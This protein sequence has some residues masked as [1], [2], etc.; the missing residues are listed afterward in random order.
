MRYDSTKSPVRRQRSLG[1]R[2][3]G[4]LTA[5]VIVSALVTGCKDSGPVDPRLA[6]L[7]PSAM[8][9]C[10]DPSLPG[11]DGGGGD[12]GPGGGINP[13]D[14]YVTGDVTIYTSTA[15]TL[16]APIYDAATEQMTTAF[17][18]SLPDEH[19]HVDAGYSTSGATIV[20]TAFTDPVDPAAS[21]SIQVTNADLNADVLTEAN[22]A[23]QQMQDVHPSDEIG[24]SPMQL[25]GSTQNADVTAGVII[26]LNDTTS[27]QPSAAIAGGTSTLASASFRRPIALA[28]ASAE[29][30]K[31]QEIDLN[32]ARVRVEVTQGMLSITELGEAGAVATAAGAGGTATAVHSRRYQKMHDNIWLLHDIRTEVDDHSSVRAVHQEHVE[33]FKRLRVFRNQQFDN[34]RRAARPTTQWIPLASSAG[35]AQFLPVSRL[36]PGSTPPGSSPPGTARPFLIYCGDECSGGSPPDYSPPSQGIDPGCARDV[37]AHV[38]ASGATVNLLY[39]HGLFDNATTWCSMDPYLRSRFTVGNEIRHS[40]VASDYY[41]NQAADLESRV[42]TD[43]GNGYP[44]PYVFIGHSNGGIVSRLSAQTLVN[45]AGTVRG[46]ITVSSPNDGAPLARVGRAAL[47][48]VIAL[49]LIGSKLGCGSISHIVCTTTRNLIGGSSATD[50]SGSDVSELVSLLDPILGAGRVLGEMTPHDPFYSN[51]NAGSEPFPR[52]AVINQAWD[53]WTEWRIWG[54]ARCRLYTACDGRHWVAGVDRTYHRYLKCA[55]IGGIFSFFIPGAGSVAQACGSSAAAL[56]GLDAG[57][58]RLS[59][60]ND[61]GDGIV[62]VTSQRYPNVDNGGQF[63]VFDSD[64]HVGVTQSTGQTG[65]GIANAMHERI[66]VPFAQ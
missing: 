2:A 54:D 59:V 56:R 14:S 61:H 27:V 46:V 50:L 47:T 35:S 4:T 6:S 51:L 44:G 31:P 58:R 29:R 37:V 45:E 40:L 55:V 65:R 63:Y 36:A 19:L 30:G 10:D 16:S 11:C 62:P 15:V 48:A 22:S 38:N 17:T 64:S 24:A 32:G 39:Q 43:I 1:P 60:G 28:A 26:D 12:P 21:P 42:R 13:N 49:P 3:R 52:A 20:N 66:S 57:Y 25:V 7:H 5:V 33:T 41:E 34:A 8:V 53:R 9:V 18:A 23:G